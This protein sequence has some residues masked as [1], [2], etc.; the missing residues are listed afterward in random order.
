M[1]RHISLTTNIKSQP[2]KID[3]LIST[4]QQLQTDGYKGVDWILFR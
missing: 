2:E 3:Q 1:K 4:A